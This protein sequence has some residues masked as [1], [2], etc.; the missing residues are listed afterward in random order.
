MGRGQQDVN[1][2]PPLVFCPLYGSLYSL[3][4]GTEEYGKY[5]L[6]GEITSTDLF[7]F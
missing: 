7:I 5:S 2:A 1:F 4:R 6:Q 3:K